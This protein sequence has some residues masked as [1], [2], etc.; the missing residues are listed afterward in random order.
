MKN[1]LLF[2]V[3]A[4]A[5]FLLFLVSC[6]KDPSLNETQLVQ[7]RDG[8]TALLQKSI[9]NGSLGGIIAPAPLTAKV[10]AYHS[11][12]SYA[13]A[14]ANANGAFR[15]EQLQAGEYS[16]IFEYILPGTGSNE[17]MIRYMKMQGIRVSSN[18]DTD[19][20]TVAVN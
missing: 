11:D 2:R 5:L 6:T 1:T 14:V 19:L 9:L 16:I 8:S 18:A 13:V 20:G 12:G 17:D 10:H 4:T 3:P 15:F 7:K